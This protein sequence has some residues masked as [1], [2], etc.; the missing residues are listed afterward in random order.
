MVMY[1]ICFF[2]VPRSNENLLIIDFL[3]EKNAAQKFFLYQCYFQMSKFPSIADYPAE[4][5]VTFKNMESAIW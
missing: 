3:S 2:L 4:I 5:K 1:S